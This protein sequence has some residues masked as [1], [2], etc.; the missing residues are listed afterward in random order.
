MLVVP[1]PDANPGASLEGVPRVEGLA[2]DSVGG[3]EE[4]SQEVEGLVEDLGPFG[5]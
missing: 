5:R 1:K 2:E 3:G 4:G